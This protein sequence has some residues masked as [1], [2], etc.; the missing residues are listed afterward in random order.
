VV[1]PFGSSPGA[2]SFGCS[3]DL[4]SRKRLPEIVRVRELVMVLGV[5]SYSLDVR[6]ACSDA[7][8]DP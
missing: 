3:G 1:D 6:E 2:L 8:E 7:H 4:C 5:E